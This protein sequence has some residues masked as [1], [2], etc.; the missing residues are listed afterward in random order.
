MQPTKRLLFVPIL[1]TTFL[2]A[3]CQTHRPYGPLGSRVDASFLQHASTADRALVTEANRAHDTAHEG[4]M[5]AQ[6]EV[7]ESEGQLAI[8][9]KTLNVANAEL[10]RAKVTARVNADEASASAVAEQTRGVRTAEAEVLGHT[11]DIGVAKHRLS[12]A[13]QKCSLA[14]AKVDLEAAKAV[15]ATGRTDVGQ[16]E[17]ADFEREVRAEE[18]DVKVAEVRLEQ[19]TRDAKA[20]KAARAAENKTLAE[21]DEAKSGG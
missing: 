21:R 18:A 19:A 10:E 11:L 3:G 8:G 4:M 6:H 17:V 15:V 5:A 1:A 12:V 9:Q 14:L 13:E 16:F 7:S 20:S 2:F